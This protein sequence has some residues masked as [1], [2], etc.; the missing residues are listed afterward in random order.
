MH[1]LA[2][3]AVSILSQNTLKRTQVP[4]FTNAKKQKVNM[5]AACQVPMAYVLSV[6]EAYNRVCDI[7]KIYVVKMQILSL[8]K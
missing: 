4:K 7:K 5:L 8:N 3:Q 2:A 6:L 1:E